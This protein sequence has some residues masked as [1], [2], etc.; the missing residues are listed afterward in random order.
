MMKIPIDE[1][2]PILWCL[3]TRIIRRVSDPEWEDY[4]SSIGLFHLK[5]IRSIDLWCNPH[6][7]GS[8]VIRNYGSLTESKF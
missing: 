5:E 8:F 2:N 3:S 7:F 6:A 1:N 4:V